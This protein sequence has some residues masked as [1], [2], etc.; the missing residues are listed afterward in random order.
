MKLFLY[1]FWSIGNRTFIG[2]KME[3]LFWVFL[4][5]LTFLLDFLV[6]FKNQKVYHPYVQVLVGKPQGP[7][8]L[9][10]WTWSS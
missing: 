6:C 4:S 8:T 2:A 3:A 1:T 5:P 7:T 9:I 10:P